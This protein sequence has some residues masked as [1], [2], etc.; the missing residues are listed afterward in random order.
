MKLQR[1]DSYQ[2]RER[3]DHSKYWILIGE[4]STVNGDLRIVRRVWGVGVSVGDWDRIRCERWVR[5]VRRVCSGSSGSQDS[6]QD[7][8]GSKAPVVEYPA[9]VYEARDVVLFWREN[10]GMPAGRS[11][12]DTLVPATRVNNQLTRHFATCFL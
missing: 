4:G 10:V 11:L 1:R 7:G 12:V 3:G 2:P 8:V 5:S 6:I 9:V